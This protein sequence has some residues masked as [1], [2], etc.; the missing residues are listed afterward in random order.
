MMIDD[1]S[2]MEDD[3]KKSVQESVPEDHVEK[4]TKTTAKHRRIYIQDSD[5][6]A[7]VAEL[8]MDTESEDEGVLGG[9]AKGGNDVL[10]VREETEQALNE[11]PEDNTDQ[12]N[13]LEEHPLTDTPPRKARTVDTKS[14]GKDS[15]DDTDPANDFEEDALTDTPPSKASKVDTTST[16]KDVTDQSKDLDD[17][18]TD[19]PPVKGSK[20]VVTSNDPKDDTDQANDY[21][22]KD[23]D[24]P[25]DDHARPDDHASKVGS[26]TTTKEGT[27]KEDDELTLA[28]L[29]K[30]VT[31]TIRKEDDD[32]GT[33]DSKADAT[34][35]KESS[36]THT[37]TKETSE[38][39]DQDDPQDTTHTKNSGNVTLES[40]QPKEN[41]DTDKDKKP[42]KESQR[43]MDTS[44]TDG[45]N[46]DESEISSA[47]ASKA[48][49]DQTEAKGSQEDIE[50][51]SEASTT[52]ES[53]EDSLSTPNKLPPK[54]VRQS[55][56]Q[57]RSST[58]KKS[59]KQIDFSA[60]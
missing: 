22:D 42:S 35:L 10:S 59:D 25:P 38:P 49:N 51:E 13:D 5:S 44:N 24:I 45:T 39:E 6:E 54:K 19:T 7:V 58:K 14:T 36:T 34:K 52:K 20:V 30:V 33:P 4:Q 40:D 18:V 28:C 27:R 46:K 55:G 41:E 31:D 23:T 60:F 57:T 26:D 17:E 2:I 29:A 11:H 56:I 32:E 12:A 3:R 50:E 37:T 48:V 43:S 21:E 1:E 16:A 15:K 8:S 9:T 53:T 47:N